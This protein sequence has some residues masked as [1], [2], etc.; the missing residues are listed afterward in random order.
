MKPLFKFYLKAFLLTGIPFGLIMTAF[1]YLDGGGF[2]LWK[3]LFHALFFGLAMSLTLVTVHKN[4]LKKHGV[5][6]FT[7][8]NLGVR[9]TKAIKTKL[10]RNELISKLK[11]DPTVA[12]LKMV[13][14]GNG[15]SLKTGIT[16]K[17]FGEDI[18][19]ELISESESD[20]EYQISSSPKIKTTIIDYGKNLENINRIERVITNM[21]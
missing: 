10:G 9:Q 14:T 15:V 1:D 5:Q 13:E 12:D 11:A 7:D 21:A 8:D 17:S 4:K 2:N 20:F 19:I 3:F 16:M 18:K 6:E